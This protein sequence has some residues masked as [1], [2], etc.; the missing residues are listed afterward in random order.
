MTSLRQ[1]NATPAAAARDAALKLFSQRIRPW[2]RTREGATSAIVAVL[3]VI[4]VWAFADA[5][6]LTALLSGAFGIVL[7]SVGA[8]AWEART[9]PP[10]PAFSRVHLA[11]TGAVEV[12]EDENA[13]FWRDNAGFLWGHRVWFAGTGCSP[14][15][16]KPGTYGRLRAWHDEDDLPVFVARASGRQWWWWQN[17]FYWESGDYEPEDMQAVLAL[18]NAEVLAPVNGSA[19]VSLEQEFSVWSAEPIPDDVKRIVCDRDEGRC[20]QCGSTELIQYDHIVPFA[21]GGGND[22]DNLRLLCAGCNRY[23]ASLARAG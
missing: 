18:L 12:Q 16:L 4:I 20:V 1:P 22:S 9:T 3:L 23:Q 21:H 2:L 8:R 17:S 14:R 13:G 10:G 7:V 19:Q 15:Q 11:T 6:F 5:S